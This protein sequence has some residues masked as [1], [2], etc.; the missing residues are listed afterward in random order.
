MLLFF[1]QQEAEHPAG[2]VVHQRVDPLAVRPVRGDQ[3]GLEHA[4][5]AG[6]QLDAVGGPDRFIHQRGQRRIGRGVHR[7][8]GAPQLPDAR[9]ER[10]V[11]L[12]VFVQVPAEQELRLPLRHAQQM[13]R[14]DEHQP[15]LDIRQAMQPPRILLNPEPHPLHVL[16][17][18]ETIVQ[19]TLT[20]LSML[21]R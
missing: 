1:R 13:P 10:L 21:H 2:R 17:A 6:Q 12:R 20:H 3:R 18:C 14:G 5:D 11:M 7:M 4:V 9:A 16:D 19:C 8:L 15:L